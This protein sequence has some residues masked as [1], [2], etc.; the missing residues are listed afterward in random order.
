MEFVVTN[1]FPW[2]SEIPGDTPG[3]SPTAKAT[4]SNLPALD[5][6]RNAVGRPFPITFPIDP[7]CRPPSTAPVSSKSAFACASPN[8][9]IPTVSTEISQNHQTNDSMKTTTFR[10][11]EEL[12]LDVNAPINP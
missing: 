10:S 7:A 12:N 9:R 8:A 3:L 6:G 11:V 2:L 4:Q 5:M 1:F